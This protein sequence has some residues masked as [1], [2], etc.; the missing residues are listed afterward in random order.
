MKENMVNVKQR[1]SNDCNVYILLAYTR[2]S[3]SKMKFQ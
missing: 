3:I 2:I 1:G